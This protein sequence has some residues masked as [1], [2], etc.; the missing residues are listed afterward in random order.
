MDQDVAK[1][2]HA[3]QCLDAFGSA[4][5]DD[6]DPAASDL[7]FLV[8]FDEV[9]PGAYAKAY[10]VLKEGLESLFGRPVDLVTSSSLANPFFR[11]RITGER[12]T[13]YAR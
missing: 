2:H 10:F 6:F 9:P 5:R 12:R 4:L 1:R 13:V 11:E 3:R 7:D 8:E